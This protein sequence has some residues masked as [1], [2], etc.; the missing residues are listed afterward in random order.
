MYFS[1]SV[2]S[3]LNIIR[4]NKIKLLALPT[5]TVGLMDVGSSTLSSGPTMAGPKSPHTTKN[6]IHVPSMKPMILSSTAS[7]PVGPNVWNATQRK[8][9]L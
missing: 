7:F 3:Q 4:A 1:V 8:S 5:R 9:N 6:A 2:Y